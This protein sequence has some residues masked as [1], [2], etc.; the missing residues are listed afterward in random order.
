MSQVHI[1]ENTKELF[2]S[3]SDDIKKLIKGGEVKSVTTILGQKYN[4]QISVY[5]R[6]SN[7]IGFI[8]IGALDPKD[9]VVALEEAL[10]LSKEDATKL[11]QDLETGILQKA[12]NM[13]LGKK[14]EP[15]ATLEFKGV[16]SQDELRKEIMDTTKR[17]SALMKPQISGIPKK[18]ANVIT[19]GSRSQLLEQ[20]QI[21]GSIPKD[22]EIEERLK[23]IQDQIS[24]IKKTE[25]DNSLKS[26]IALKSFMFG[27]KGK[28][29]APAIQK[30][31]TYS[32]A[33]T[34]YN[35]DPYRE[36]AED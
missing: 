24:S 14:E 29:T 2:D 19:P 11:A 6:L 9:S 34:R 12:R 7:I 5:V 20:L 25:E 18:T 10:S 17:E 23:H 21:L 4:L 15:V 28:D 33:P 27:D 16:K 35:L 32:V 3:S 1:A 31:A 13:M 8:L 36:V 26:N 22:E 30:T